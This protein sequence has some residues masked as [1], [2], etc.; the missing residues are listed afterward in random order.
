MNENRSFLG[1]LFDISFSEFITTRIIKVLYVI[2]IVLAVFAGIG[3]IING[4]SESVGVGIIS[5][6]LAPIAFFLYVLVA[7]VWL[8]IM[9]VIFRIAEDTRKLV[10]LKSEG[11][12]GQ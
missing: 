11:K 4:F 7:R 8:E 6:V 2:A 1:H 5:L 9:I 3:I 12:A 10:E